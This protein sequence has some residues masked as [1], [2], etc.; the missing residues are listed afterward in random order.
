MNRVLASCIL[1]FCVKGIAADPSDREFRL[2]MMVGFGTYIRFFPYLNHQS[3]ILRATGRD[4]G[5]TSTGW[6]KDASGVAF[7]LQFDFDRWRA[8]LELG[9]TGHEDRQMTASRV[10]NT[11]S[12]Q[13]E[14]HYLHARDI[15]RYVGIITGGYRLRTS[16]NL[17]WQL[18]GMIY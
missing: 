15:G 1:F 3:E 10:R 17:E 9:G 13:F 7:G 12:E 14:L 8:E 11:T 18:C 6:K 4:G 5:A 16:R 2:H